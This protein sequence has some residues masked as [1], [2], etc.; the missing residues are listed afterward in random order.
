[1]FAKSH[2]G[3]SCIGAYDAFGGHVFTISASLTNI[4]DVAQTPNDGWHLEMVGEVVGEKLHAF[5]THAKS[6]DGGDPAQFGGPI[7]D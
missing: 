4:V 1:M 6:L 5:G 3:S 7:A 2:G